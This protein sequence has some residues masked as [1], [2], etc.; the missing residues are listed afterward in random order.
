MVWLLA[1]ALLVV[2]WFVFPPFRKF[3]LVVGG[4]LVLLMAG[5]LL[6]YNHEES[7]SRSLIPASN[8]EL[9]EMRLHSDSSS[10]YELLGEVRNTSEHELTGVLLKV[11][12]YDCPGPSITSSCT[13][14]GEDNSV[15]IYVDVPTNQV[16]TIDMTY[17]FLPSMPAP[18][19]TFLWSYK[20]IGTQG[21]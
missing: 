16:R 17:V 21:R 14:I 13:T 2:F 10:S 4:F 11:T 20:I 19:G 18:K 6:Y 3:V 15:S 12:A 8:V 7:V 9:T 1:I 5:T